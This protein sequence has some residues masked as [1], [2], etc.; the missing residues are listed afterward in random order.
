[1]G[2]DIHPV[3]EKRWKRDNGT[4]KWVGLHDFPYT[5]IKEVRQNGEVVAR[6]Y[7]HSPPA[8]RRN[9]ELFAK[10]AGVRGAGPE[11]RGLPEDASDLSL[12]LLSDCSD[13]HSHS[14]VMARDYVAAA[15]SCEDDPAKL[16]LNPDPKDKRVC[17]PYG[18]FLGIDGLST[19]YGEPHENPDDF[20]I[21]FTF[22]N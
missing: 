10:L 9:Y 7:W 3:L 13:Y 17:D 20:R 15:L 22:D 16:F 12:M 19:E 21:V 14:W 5:T 2:C 6:N 1:M 8:Q 11:P 4:S 18:Y